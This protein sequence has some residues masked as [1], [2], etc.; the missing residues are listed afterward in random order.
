MD[1]VAAALLTFLG[2]G[3]GIFLSRFLTSDT[4]PTSP[5]LDRD[6]LA[7]LTQRCAAAEQIAAQAT[8]LGNQLAAT[9]RERATQAKEVAYLR[10]QNE[11][12]TAAMA[13]AASSAQARVM[14][15]LQPPRSLNPVIGIEDGYRQN[16]PPSA[17]ADTVDEAPEG[18]VRGESRVLR[19]IVP[20]TDEEE[21]LDY[22][23]VI[24][25]LG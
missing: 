7:V 13:E 22:T 23:D 4:K 15:L 6:A 5:T 21:L 2:V 20:G 12:L 11:R 1:Q 16:R 17:P 25:G 3:I 8:D 24:G 9:L 19:R 14:Q 10:E 18:P